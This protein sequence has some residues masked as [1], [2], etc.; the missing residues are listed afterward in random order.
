MFSTYIA[1]TSSKFI[2]TR[3]TRQNLQVWPKILKKLSKHQIRFEGKK[4]ILKKSEKA[5]TFIW[6]LI[7][8][9]SLGPR[10][11]TGAPY[12][13]QKAEVPKKTTKNDCFLQ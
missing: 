10:F 4:V 13:P 2:L 9:L 8:G 6:E 1:K 12:K 3:L 7:K 11:L 5:Q